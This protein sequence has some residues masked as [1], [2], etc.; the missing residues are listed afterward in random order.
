MRLALLCALNAELA[1]RRACALVTPLDGSEAFLFR[2]GQTTDNILA[3]AIDE[4]LRTGR[5]G[6]ATH[7]AQRVFINVHTPPVRLIVI[8]AVHIA[9]TLA[10]MARLSGVDVVVVD[11]RSAFAAT[12][13]FP[14]TPIL[15]LWPDEALP[16]LGLDR[17][18][19]LAA[20]THDPKI[21][22]PAL[23]LALASECFYI[24]ALG[25]KRS[26]SK[27]VE[28]LLAGG[29]ASQA[30]ARVH[31]PIGLDIGAATSE[32]IAVAVLGEIISSLRRKPLRER[33]A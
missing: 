32:E 15:T 7:N 20:L 6:I 31:A 9:Q 21:D 2:V 26:H 29:V 19:A 25:S 5:S 24:G 30:L 14:D 27:R 13:R 4:Q 8:G 16:A 12:A 17:F 3:G 11:P 10:P 18:T 23:R 28:R 22:D 1:A 33:S